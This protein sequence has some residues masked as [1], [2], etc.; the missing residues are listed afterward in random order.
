MPGGLLLFPFSGALSFRP[1]SFGIGAFALALPLSFR[2]FPLAFSF[3]VL[4][5]VVRAVVTSV[6]LPEVTVLVTDVL[7][8]WR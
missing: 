5:V 1:S 6:T 3:G 8:A 4:V 2:T 7:S